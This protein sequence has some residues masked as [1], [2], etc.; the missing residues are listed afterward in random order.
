MGRALHSLGKEPGMELIGSNE[1]SNA[2][3][4][5]RAPGRMQSLKKR[6]TR[7]HYRFRKDSEAN[8]SPRVRSSESTHDWYE[9]EHG[10]KV[11]N[12]GINE[13]FGKEYRT[14]AGLDTNVKEERIGMYS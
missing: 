13:Q 11:L 1:T 9:A 14:P 5:L 7:L 2:S 10:Y 12:A 8:G 6:R 3:T 4:I